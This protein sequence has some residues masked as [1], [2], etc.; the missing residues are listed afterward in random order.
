[1]GLLPGLIPGGPFGVNQAPPFVSAQSCS[2]FSQS[3][4]YDFFIPECNPEAGFSFATPWGP[5]AP[6]APSGNPADINKFIPNT[7]VPGSGVAAGIAQGQPLFTFADYNRA[8]KL[9][10]TLN[11]TLDIQWQPRNDLAIDIGYV[12]NLGRHEVVPL[13]F[14]QAQI[15]SPSKPIR[16]GTPLEQDYTY[17]YAIQQPGCFTSPQACT[18]NLPNGQPYQANYEGGNVDLRGAVYRVFVRVRVIHRSRCL[19]YNAL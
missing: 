6:T 5:T 13:P 1:M 10:Y 11:Q 16:P 4:V 2:S 3:F 12:G 15:A 7:G 14:N 17:G 18:I 19:G 8:N 9:P